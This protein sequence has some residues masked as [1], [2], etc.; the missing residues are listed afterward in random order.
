MHYT[1][2]TC[3]SAHTYTQSLGE[4]VCRGQ[5]D[6]EKEREKNTCII[7]TYIDDV[8]RY[9]LASVF[10]LSSWRERGNEEKEGEKKEEEEEGG[11]GGRREGKE[12]EKT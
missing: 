5:R 9:R 3:K 11:G 4:Y 1:I 2:S 6:R 8:V 12:G 7:C 10:S